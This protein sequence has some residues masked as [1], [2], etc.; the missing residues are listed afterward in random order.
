MTR[1]TDRFNMKPILTLIALIVVIVF[2]WLF[3]SFAGQR[4]RRRDIAAF[5]SMANG[6]FSL[7]F[8][9]ALSSLSDLATIFFARLSHYYFALLCMGI[10]TVLVTRLCRASINSTSRS[11]LG[12]SLIFFLGFSSRLCPF[13]SS[14]IDCKNLRHTSIAARTSSIFS[15]LVTGEYLKRLKLS[16]SSTAFHV[17]APLS[18]FSYCTS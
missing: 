15:A 17:F 4:G 2:G 3:A 5:N 13:G 10:S 14:F 7:E 8:E 16:T 11:T 18:D 12:R 9:S 6:Y 1:S